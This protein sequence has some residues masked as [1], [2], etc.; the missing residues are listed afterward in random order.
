M[1][2][3]RKEVKRLGSATR[4]SMQGLQHAWR[5]EAAFRF[6][7]ILAVLMLPVA[8]VLDVAPL[9]RIALVASIF[10]VLIVELINSAVEAVVDRIGPEHHPLSGRAKDL[11]SAA[12]FLA[13]LLT[14]FVWLTILATTFRI[15]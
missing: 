7:V 4:F 2:L 15:I 5:G 1:E 10:L 6:E 8:L 14:L 13:L 3:I 11:G 12:V 9:E